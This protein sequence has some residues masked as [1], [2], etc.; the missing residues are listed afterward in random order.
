[1]VSCGISGEVIHWL[2]TTWNTILAT[3]R[4]AA[5][6]IRISPVQLKNEPLA[7]LSFFVLASQ[8]I[9]KWIVFVPR[10]ASAT[11]VRR[12]LD[13]RAQ[14]IFAGSDDSNS[15]ILIPYIYQSPSM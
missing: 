11:A 2:L 6:R 12:W 14:Q 3:L 7:G 4:L 13:S 1:M 5:N 9:R 15:N 10:I 8:S